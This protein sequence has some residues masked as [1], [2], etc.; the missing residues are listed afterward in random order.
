MGDGHWSFERSLFKLY[1]TT[2]L[3]LVLALFPGPTTFGCTKKVFY[4][5][6]KMARAW[7]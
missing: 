2:K 1:T 4:V 3:Q 7:K 6:P 5:Q